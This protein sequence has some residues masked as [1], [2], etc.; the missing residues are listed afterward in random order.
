MLWKT[1]F[2]CLQQFFFIEIYLIYK[3]SGVQQSVSVIYILFHCKL[4]Q[5]IEYSSLC[6]TVGLCCLSIIFKENASVN[7]KFPIHPLPCF[8]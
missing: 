1:F 5:D 8:L 2:V 3:I 7:P 6:Y 4:L